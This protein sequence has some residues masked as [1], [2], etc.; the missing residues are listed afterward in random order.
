MLLI[1]PDPR[2]DP[3]NLDMPGMTMVFK[4][5]NPKMLEVKPGSE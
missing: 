4:V 5:A 2:L 1:T 3:L